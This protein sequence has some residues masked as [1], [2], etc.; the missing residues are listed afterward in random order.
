MVL[1][2]E[3]G[4]GQQLKRGESVQVQELLD[5]S[6]SNT[7]GVVMGYLGR[8]SNDYNASLQ[9]GFA[10]RHTGRTPRVGQVVL[11]SR[12]LFNDNLESPP[13]YVPAVIANILFI[14][15]MLLSSM[16]IVREKEKEEK[17]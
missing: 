15:T 13:F 4:F 8:L 1:K 6:D 3:H 11:A 10:A 5:G 7:A 14:I 16:A 9:A 12:A 17:S 2:I